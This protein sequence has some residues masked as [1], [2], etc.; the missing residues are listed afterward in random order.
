MIPPPEVMIPIPP[1]DELGPQ[2]EKF[3]GSLL[4]APSGRTWQIIVNNSIRFTLGKGEKLDKKTK[5]PT[6]HWFWYFNPGPGGG[7]KTRS[8]VGG[9]KTDDEALVDAYKK[10]IATFPEGLTLTDKFGEE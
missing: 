1:E 6:E 8:K 5:E 3:I 2:Y 4:E 10:L 9:F 7:T